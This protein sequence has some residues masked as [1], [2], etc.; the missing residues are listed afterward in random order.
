MTDPSVR[1]ATAA[2]LPRLPE[3]EASASRLFAPTAK[4]MDIL[5]TVSPAET[6]AGMQA[7][8]TVWIVDDAGVPVAFLAA[9]VF[10]DELHVWELDVHH[11]HQRQGHG[12]RLMEHAI[13]W[14]RARRMAAVTLTTFRDIAWNAPFY[15]SLG[16]REVSGPDVSVRLAKVLDLEASKGLN[17]AERCAMVLELQRIGGA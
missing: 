1:E 7:A 8:G 12:R 14:A 16:F 15:A 11:D 17:P 2:E 10:G 6:W 9:Q 5:A 3:I 13:A 4:P